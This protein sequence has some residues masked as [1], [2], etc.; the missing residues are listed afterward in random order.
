MMSE[1]SNEPKNPQTTPVTLGRSPS[2]SA[3]IAGEKRS[4]RIWKE[5]R[6]NPGKYI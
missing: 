3:R 5:D 6:R 1:N 2:F 4:Y